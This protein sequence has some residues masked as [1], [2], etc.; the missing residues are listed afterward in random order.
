[1]VLDSVDANTAL[2]GAG[3]QQAK[4]L[5]LTRID[6]LHKSAIEDYKSYCLQ[7][8]LSYEKDMEESNEVSLD[9]N[10]EDMSVL[11]QDLNTDMCST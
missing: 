6:G 7:E 2:P 1:M 9:L 4:L 5:M 3:D 11:D 8:I 10:H